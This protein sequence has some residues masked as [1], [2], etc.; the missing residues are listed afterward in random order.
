MAQS[1]CGVTQ[2]VE[3]QTHPLTVAILRFIQLSM[4]FN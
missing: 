4:P 2:G 3:A 1:R